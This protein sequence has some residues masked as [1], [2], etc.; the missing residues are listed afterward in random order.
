MRY[1]FSTLNYYILLIQ[2]QKAMKLYCLYFQKFIVKLKENF[3]VNLK[4]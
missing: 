2:K 1:S 4:S 3:F